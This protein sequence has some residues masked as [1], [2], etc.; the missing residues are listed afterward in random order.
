MSI[1]G[2]PA[3]SDKI[4]SSVM[5]VCSWRRMFAVLLA[6]SL[7]SSGFVYIYVY[8]GM[9]VTPARNQAEKYWDDIIENQFTQRSVIVTRTPP[10]KT[11]IIS[12]TSGFNRSML[13]SRKYPPLNG[14]KHYDI[15]TNHVRYNRHE[16][17]AVIPNATYITILRHPV[18][19]IVS[20]FSYFRWAQVINRYHGNKNALV[21]FM[22]N[23]AKFPKYKMRFWWQSHNGQLYD[24]GFRNNYAN[25]TDDVIH[26]YIEILDKE[27][28]LV[29]I[30][31][32]FDESLLVL[33]KQLCW[34][35]DDIIYIPKGV[36]TSRHI[37]TQQTRDRIMQWNR[38][39][40]LLYEHFNRTLWEKITDY[41]PAFERDL[42]QFRDKRHTTMEE[43]VDPSVMNTKDPR[44]RKY[45]LKSN[46]A[47]KCINMWLSDVRFTA[48][49]RDK[50]GKSKNNIPNQGSLNKSN[51]TQ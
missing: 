29:L 17:E 39:D 11:Q 41:G 35:M 20:A 32:Y 14:G 31:E 10:T 51:V 43:C 16:M 6:L 37:L 12:S 48:L 13:N 45:V 26:K 21:T 28:D 5:L 7:V 34:S 4:N 24:L 30:T 25:I 42:Q 46:A 18:N 2:I 1:S 38:G 8:D 44:E 50:Q 49:I 23:P 40:F 33:K 22:E 3:R 9:T 47:D 19:Q 15:L 27:M 36:G